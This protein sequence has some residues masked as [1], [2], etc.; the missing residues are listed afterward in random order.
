MVRRQS[1]LKAS[2][3][4]HSAW[5]MSVATVSLWVDLR[6]MVPLISYFLWAF[7]DRLGDTELAFKV[8]ETLAML[9]D[10]RLSGERW[11]RML[12]RPARRSVLRLDYCPESSLSISS[13]ALWICF[14]LS[15]LILESRSLS[16][17]IPRSIGIFS[18]KLG[19]LFSGRSRPRLE[20]YRCLQLL[21]EPVESNE[22]ISAIAFITELPTN[23]IVVG[24]DHHWCTGIWWIS[25]WISKVV[26][27]TFLLEENLAVPALA[28]AVL[29]G[30]LSCFLVVLLITNHNGFEL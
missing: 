16:S 30:S 15:L 10:S 18:L 2:E 6:S 28:L 24:V 29:S 8:G 1:R 23:V 22:I 7:F 20:H 21:I 9:I 5:L 17:N 3:R 4:L 11:H 19:W 27:D 26:P 14:C 13:S 25:L 12:L